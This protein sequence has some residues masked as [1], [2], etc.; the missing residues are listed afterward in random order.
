MSAVSN[1]LLNLWS[2]IGSA[3]N[4]L[5]LANGPIFSTYS[6]AENDRIGTVGYAFARPEVEKAVKAA[7]LV[8]ERGELAL[9]AIDAELAPSNVVDF[10]KEPE[11]FQ[12][13][14]KVGGA[15]VGRLVPRA[16]PTGPE[17]A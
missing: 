12:P 2:G 6:R 8:I 11:S 4:D 13:V 16:A 5:A 3:V 1:A 7:K 9:A 14:G 17:A 10:D 15:V